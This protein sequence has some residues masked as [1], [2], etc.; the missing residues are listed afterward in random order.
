MYT[1]HEWTL[2]WFG[3]LSPSVEISLQGFAGYM[4][5]AFW[6]WSEISSSSLNGN[7]PLRLK[8]NHHIN[9]L[10]VNDIQ[11]VCYHASA[12]SFTKVSLVCNCD[13]HAWPLE[14]QHNAQYIPPT[15]TRRNCFVLSRRRCVNEFATSSRRLPTD[16]VD[17]L[18]TGQTDSMAVW[19]TMWILID[20]D[21]FFN[22]DDIMM[23]LL[24]KLSIFIKIG[25]IKRYGVCL[26]SF[27]IVDRICR[28]SSWASCELCSHRRPVCIHR[29]RDET[30]QFCSVGGVYWALLDF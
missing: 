9:K 1:L 21:N 24:K 12:T 20:T 23:S 13:I 15:P 6:I 25:V 19:R 30:Q 14:A 3:D 28:Q 4:K 2:F 22:S 7:V 18:E 29:R 27:K 10:Q 5:P 16:S 17:N 8:R 26:V 11:L